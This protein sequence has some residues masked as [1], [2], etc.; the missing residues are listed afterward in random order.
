MDRATFSLDVQIPSLNDF[1]ALH[2]NLAAIASR[3]GHPF[4]REIM[5]AGSFV[6]CASVTDLLHLPAVAGVAARLEK[7]ATERGKP[8]TDQEKQFVGNVVADI[9]EANGYER[10]EKSGRVGVLP[11]NRGKIFRRTKSGKN[12]FA[13]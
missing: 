5:T 4:F 10:T 13:Q 1:C 11:F 7:V 2:P 12:P 9:M 8:M 6:A 3:E